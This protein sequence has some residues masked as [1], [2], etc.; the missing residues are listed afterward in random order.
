[1]GKVERKNAK[2]KNGKYH[3]KKITYNGS[4]TCFDPTLPYINICIF[5]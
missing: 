2:N 5:S 3:F 1:M 4:C